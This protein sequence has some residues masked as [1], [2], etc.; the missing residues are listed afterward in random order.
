MSRSGKVATFLA[1]CPGICRCLGRL[2]AFVELSIRP[3]SIGKL[4]VERLPILDTAAQKL[5][6]VRNGEGFRDRLWQQVPKL[7]MMPAQIVTAAVAV[8]AN[9]RAQPDHLG[10]QSS[11]VRL[12]RSSSIVTINAK[13][14]KL[15][16]SK[17]ASVRLS[18][19]PDALNRLKS[20][21]Q[22]RLPSIQPCHTTRKAGYCLGLPLMRSKPTK[23]DL[24]RTAGFHPLSDIGLI[25]FGRN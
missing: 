12:G 19:S 20:L 24:A 14:P 7:R 15:A 6:P 10:D 3:W 13:A 18:S 2:R 23:A 1:P 22:H 9:S 5:R 11:L 4:S 25:G 21:R 16:E 8:G 17:H